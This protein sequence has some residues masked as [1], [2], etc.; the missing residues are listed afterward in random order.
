MRVLDDVVRGLRPARVAGQA[1]L[2][3][4]RVELARPAGE[5]LVDVR[6]VTGVEDDLVARGV[7]DP[8]HRHGELDDAEVGP[9]MAPGTGHLLDEEHPDLGSQS[10]ELVGAQFAKVAGTTEPLEQHH[11]LTF[12]SPGQ[13]YAGTS[14]AY[15]PIAVGAGTTTGP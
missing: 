11:S 8:V 2:L 4:Q 10:G 6:L 3:S 14:L 5:D 13:S 12:A 15:S 7:E 9:E 1:A